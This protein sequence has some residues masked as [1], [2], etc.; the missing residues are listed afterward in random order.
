MTE[1]YSFAGCSMN[2]KY[3]DKYTNFAIP[4][5]YGTGRSCSTW[6]CR[7]SESSNSL[8]HQQKWLH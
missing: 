2:T 7:V 5:H 6:S 8:T 4:A 3:A 1:D